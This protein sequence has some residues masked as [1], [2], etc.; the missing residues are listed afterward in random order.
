[1]TKRAEELAESIVLDVNFDIG[2]HN[3]YVISRNITKALIQMRKET[4]EECAKVADKLHNTYDPYD[5]RY[6]LAQAIRNLNKEL[7]DA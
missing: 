7:T 1:M 5:H 6:N 2:G 4:I 3:R